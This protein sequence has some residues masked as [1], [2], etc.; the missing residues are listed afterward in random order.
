MHYNEHLPVQVRT[1]AENQH[2]P[3]KFLVQILMRLKAAG[4]INSIRGSSGGYLLARHPS[5]V[6][7]ADVITA[8]DEEML[9]EGVASGNSA[10]SRGAD[11]VRRLWQAVSNEVNDRLG[12]IDFEELTSQYQK[13]SLTYSI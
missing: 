11:V 1:I 7:V 2:I 5:R 10:S 4:L 6:S 12:N 3:Q 9:R 8:I 13:G